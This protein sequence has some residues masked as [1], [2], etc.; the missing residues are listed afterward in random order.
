MISALLLLAPF[1]SFASEKGLLSEI[2]PSENGN[3]ESRV[4]DSELLVSKAEN[5]AIKSLEKLI[6]KSKGTSEEPQLIFRLAELYMRRAKTGR[7]FEMQN[8]EELNT[9]IQFF[10][11]VEKNSRAPLMQA[12]LNYEKIENRFQNFSEMDQILFQSGFALQQLNRKQESLVKYQKLLKK[13]EKSLLRS[14]AAIAVGEIYFENQKYQEAL[15]NFKISESAAITKNTPYAIYKSAWCYYNLK[16]NQ[17]AVD[18]LT[19]LL[20]DSQINLLVRQESIRDLTL[21]VSEIKKSSEILS[22]FT[23]IV[24]PTELSQVIQDLSKLY[25]KHSRSKEALEFLQAFLDNSSDHTAAMQAR[26]QMMEAFENLKQHDRTLDIMRIALD[27]CGQQQAPARI[28][29]CQTDVEARVLKIAQDWWNTAQNAKDPVRKKK[30]YDS[31]ENALIELNVRIK[32]I[33]P[34]FQF[35]AAELLF[36]REKWALAAGYYQKVYQNDKKDLKRA[37]ESQY[38]E[39]VCL[40]KTKNKDQLRPTVIALSEIF[41]KQYPKNTNADSL[42]LRLAELYKDDHNYPAA[43]KIIEKIE[44]RMV[45]AKD[46]K[47]QI[48]LEQNEYKKAQAQMDTDIKSEGNS[49]RAKKLSRAQ[50]E[51]TLVGIQNNKKGL[52]KYLN[53]LLNYAQHEQQVDLAEKAFFDGLAQASKNRFTQAALE[54]SNEIRKRFPAHKKIKELK[55]S[56]LQYML[57]LGQFKEA[58]AIYETKGEHELAAELYRLDGQKVQSENILKSIEKQN[59]KENKEPFVTRQ[60]VKQLKNLFDAGKMKES[61]D[62]AKKIIARKV[63]SSERAPARYY[64]ALILEKEFI[65]QSLKSSDPSRLNLLLEYKLEKF[66]KV[67]TAFLGTTQMT[68]NA[69]IWNDAFSGIQRSL[70]SMIED[71]KQIKSGNSSKEI[72]QALDLLKQ[73]KVEID[74]QK[75]NIAQTLL[76]KSMQNP[77]GKSTVHIEK[78]KRYVDLKKSQTWQNL[79]SK[80]KARLISQ[81]SLKDD[82]AEKAIVATALQSEDEG[83]FEKAIWY[84]SRWSQK[85]K[86]DLIQYHLV[87]IATKNSVKIDQHLIGSGFSKSYS[88]PEEKEFLELIA[89]QKR[90]QSSAKVDITGD[91]DKN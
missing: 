41:L 66:E 91:I 6:E 74:Q 62:F 36:Q 84:L 32:R 65:A 63:D 28:Q 82:E 7:F 55:E 1:F 83:Q 16:R 8:K 12:L 53:D 26:I 27:V 44:A 54:F 79:D 19:R 88:L 33:V 15:A 69:Q 56:Q 76:N 77:N 52:Q 89:S 90:N 18:T 10:P 70:D 2:Q 58:A 20:K 49:D 60:M 31:A 37:E 81:S 73:K 4:L 64:Q 21:F 86:S 3:E 34:D 42:M 5:Q 40:E 38:A 46:L 67:Q 85:L 80:E 30:Y 48:Y 59:L 68:D 25:L 57:D 24:S 23:K 78:W 11:I 35:A 39:I 71:L 43:L 29:E 51:L 14:D 22:F 13:F 17:D 9:K 75:Q 61:F 47:I 45:A 50:D 72:A 87:R